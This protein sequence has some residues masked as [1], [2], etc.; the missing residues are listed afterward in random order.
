MRTFVQLLHPGVE[1]AIANG[2]SVCPVNTGPNHKRKFL[3]TPADYLAPGSVING[4]YLDTNP[5]RAIKGNV[6]F[7]GEWEL[8]SRVNMLSPAP[9]VRRGLP[10]YI[11]RP[12]WPQAIINPA[13]C[14]DP[15][16]NGYQN[17]DPFV[18]CEPFL[19]FCCK[20]TPNGALNRLNPGDVIVFGSHLAGHF[21]LD[22]VF[23]VKD[24]IDYHQYNQLQPNTLCPN[25][26]Q[27]NGPHL[28]KLKPQRNPLRVYQGATYQDQVDGMFSFFPCKSTQPNKPAPFARPSLSLPG[29]VEPKMTQNF[30]STPTVGSTMLKQWTEIV[31]TLSS[32]KLS[33]GLK[34]YL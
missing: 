26:I 34:A 17:T 7:W 30:K 31:R 6:N 20:I 21:V 12:K 33:L 27:I 1:P 11:H 24:W 29:F 4:A 8:A 28:E 32:A 10:R 15:T 9:P 19:Y 25:F 16:N 3:E 23:V 14:N 18:F 2:S 5:D 22:T 13:Q